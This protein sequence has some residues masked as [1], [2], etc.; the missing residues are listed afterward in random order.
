[1]WMLV[2]ECCIVSTLNSLRTVVSASNSLLGAYNSQIELHT[3]KDEQSSTS[4][5][6][7]K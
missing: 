4:N 5:C 3:T 6:V 2:T 7:T 1:M